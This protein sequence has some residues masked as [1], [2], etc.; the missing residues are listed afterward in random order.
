M[1]LQIIPLDYPNLPIIVLNFLQYNLANSGGI[2]ICIGQE[3]QSSSQ[4]LRL[5]T[6]LPLAV[7]DYLTSQIIRRLAFSLDVNSNGRKRR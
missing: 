3:N 6:P 5:A 7:P 2:M 1:R 4:F